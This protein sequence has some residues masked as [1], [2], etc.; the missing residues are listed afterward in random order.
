MAVDAQ[1]LKL[2]GEQDKRQSNYRQVSRDYMKN[3]ASVLDS[4]NQ[5]VRYNTSQSN[6]LKSGLG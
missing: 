3:S 4:I 5:S 6:S 1:I 2:L